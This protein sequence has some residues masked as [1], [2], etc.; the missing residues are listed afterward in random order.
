MGKE[1][2]AVSHSS[3]A[4]G[5]ILKGEIIADNDV[6]IDGTIEGN[7]DCKGKVIIGPT[8]KVIG[9]IICVNAEVIGS[10]TG[11][12]K[13]HET[14]TLQSSGK[15]NGDIQTSILIIQPNA[16]FNGSCTMGGNSN[17][18]EKNNNNEKK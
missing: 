13:V 3:L 2:S 15:I 17:K 16:I 5:C 10:L 18:N 14:L 8:G 4:G 6:R 7:V 11:N 1:V 9:N 12:M